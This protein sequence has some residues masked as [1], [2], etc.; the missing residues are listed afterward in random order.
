[1]DR[2]S[3]VHFFIQPMNKPSHRVILD[4]A[5]NPATSTS[6][7]SIYHGKSSVVVA[8]V[9]LSQLIEV[10]GCFAFAQHDSAL[11]KMVLNRPLPAV[12]K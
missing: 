7:E 2:S 10:A 11:C 3:G 1:M 6:F 8:A 4:E 9:L 5:T 12:K